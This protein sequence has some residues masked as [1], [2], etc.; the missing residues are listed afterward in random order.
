[1]MTTLWGRLRDYMPDTDML[2]DDE[3]QARHRVVLVALVGLVAVTSAVGVARQ[4][5]GH[6]LLDMAVVYVALGYA[7]RTRNRLAGMAVV[8]L[9]I[10]VSSSM[11]V[12]FTD[13]LIESHFTY[14]VVLPVI[15]LY[16]DWRPF[17][18]SVLFVAVT[19]GVMGVLAPESMYNHA[20]AIDRPIL[21]GLVHAAYVLALTVAMTVHWHFAER[22]RHDLQRVVEDLRS[23]QT[24]LVEARK[25]E[26]MGSLAAGLAHEIN[27]PVQF[28]GTNLEFITDAMGD[29]AKVLAAYEAAQADLQD[30]PDL[31]GLLAEPRRLAEEADLAFLLE[32]VPTAISQS[33]DGIARVAEIVRAMRGFSHPGEEPVP[34]DVNQLVTDTMVLSRQEWNTTAQVS[35]HLADDLPEVPLVPPAFNQVL[36]NL[37]VNASHAIQDRPE[38]APRRGRIRLRTAFEDGEVSVEV[39]DN[40]CGIPDD[41]AP[42]VF[43]QFFTTKEVGRGTGQGLS[44]AHSIVT[45]MGGTLTFDA[46]VGVGTTFRFTVPLVRPEPVPTGVPAVAG[47]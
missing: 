20:A 40:G 47:V 26:S 19:H 37:L 43:D 9:G 22:P 8:S 45:E 35:V 38:D 30:R 16:H 14:F 2:P 1:M 27:T 39:A 34:T 29:I 21:W 24:Q 3:W 15:A 31:D 12:H 23:A 33:Q 6:G 11:M 17:L 10:L 36:L 32:E 13:G 44:L 5:L 28:V 18:L 42:R 41:V 25:L 46:T 4:G 7:V